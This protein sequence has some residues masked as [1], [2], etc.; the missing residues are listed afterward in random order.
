MKRVKWIAAVL[1]V[2]LLLLSS[3]FSGSRA[4]DNT[5]EPIIDLTPEEQVFIEQHPVIRLGV[6]PNFVPYEFFDT[7]G[8]YKG[9]AADY[10]ALICQ[11]TGLNMQVQEGLTWTEAYEKAVTGE[12]DAL[13]CV[14]QTA[15]RERYFLFSDTYFTFQRAVFLNEETKDINKLSDLYGKTI[16]VQM[17]SS[18]HS[19]LTQFSE[20]KLSLYP[21]VEAGLRAVSQGTELAFVG[22]M[23]TSSY[24]ARQNGITNLKYFTIDPAPGDP[25]QTLHFA[26]RKDWPELVSIINK[27]L[28]SI[29]TEERTAINTKWVDVEATVDYQDL[30]RGIG[31]GVGILALVV[32][33]SY[34]WIIRLRKEIAKRKKAQEELVLAKEEAE[35][36]NQVKSL[37][38]ARMSHEIRTPLNAIMGMAYLIKKTDLTAT[39]NSYLDKL[40]Q[41]ARTMLSTINDILDFSK[42]EAGK[43]TIERISFDLDKL[44]QKIVNIESVKVEEQGIELLLEKDPVLPSF[45]FGDPLRLEQILLNLVNNAVKFTEHGQV[46]L[47][48]RPA[49]EQME[50]SKL[51]FIVSDTGIGMSREQL[52]HLFV[53]FDQGD[54]SISRRFGGSGLGL[55]IVKSLLELMNGEISVKSEPNVGSVFAVILP[56]EPDAVQERARSARMSVECFRSMRALVLDQS[57]SARAQLGE[58]FRSFGIAAEMAETPEHAQQL[59]SQGVKEGKPYSILL[60]DHVT[61]REN[62]IEWFR[63]LKRRRKLPDE[64]KTILLMPMMREDLLEELEA[65]GLD[66]G[67]TKPVIPS[68]LY[69]GIIEILK[70][71]PPEERQAAKQTDSKPLSHP[72]RLLL[73]EDNKTN[74]FIAKSILEQ[75]GFALDVA[76][77]G[78]EGWRFFA[79]HPDEIDLIL[80]D[81]HMPVM[82][83]YTASGLI[84]KIDADIPIVAMTADAIA[85]VEEQC[86]AHGIYHYVSKPFEPEQLIETLAGLLEGKQPRRGK[87]PVEAAEEHPAMVDFADGRKRIGGDDAIYRLVLKSFLEETASVETDL[88]AVVQSKDYVQG[89]QIVHKLKSSAGSIG[90]KSLHDAAVELQQAFKEGGESAITRLL[91]PFLLALEQARDALENY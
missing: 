50:L 64:T 34:L 76:S 5:P 26:V 84:R 69:N 40:S 90:A 66:F 59:I 18:H 52:E 89:E 25:S 22:N 41:A 33:V 63:A 70:I 74:Q 19:Y 28:A 10:I 45:F 6:D 49:E 29:T 43:I 78:E 79:A 30:L 87:V 86:R 57:E 55:S 51:E 42:I 65:A 20:V 71:K 38:L 83:G 75:A 9:I 77:D 8:V 23:A 54:S 7:D 1:A 48:V 36:A 46:K 12:L 73:V 81:L 82:D 31:V 35:Q 4:Q 2:F 60:I 17:N 14:A 58:C 24:L 91:K 3:P 47:I 61:P 80:M 32:M 44:L 11:R 56:L 72:Y 16:A 39:Q 68:V 53:A 15:E 37:F 21:T 27:A 62:G 85:G 88:N 67:M 13:P